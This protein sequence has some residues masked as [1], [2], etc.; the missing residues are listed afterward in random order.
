[1]EA[2]T[3][4]VAKG[5]PDTVIAACRKVVSL[6][7]LRVANLR[8]LVGS[9]PQAVELYRKSLL[10]EDATQTRTAL[11]TAALFAGQFDEVIAQTAK[12]LESN[13]ND[14]RLWYLNGKGWMGKLDY[15]SAVDSL[16]QSLALRRDVNTQYAL[17][18]SYLKLKDKANGESVIRETLEQQGDRP[19]WHIIFGG[20]YRES[21]YSQD[22]IREFRRAIAMNNTTPRA[23]LYLALA[24]LEANGWAPLEDSVREL[25]EAVSQ[26]PKDFHAN[27]YLG[28]QESQTDRIADSNKHLKAAAEIDSTLPEIWL[29]LGLN[30]FKE[31]KVEDAKAFL[32]KAIQLTGTNEALGGYEIRRGYTVLSRIEFAAGN[33]EIAKKYSEKAKELKTI[34]MVDEAKGLTN[35]AG[36]MGAPG[37]VPH[38][39]FPEQTLPKEYARID[40]T[41]RLE[42]AALAKTTLPLAEQKR[43]E[44]AEHDLRMVLSNAFNDWGT[45]DAR[46]GLYALA[47]QHFQEAEQWDSSTPGVA[48]NV[49]LAALKTGDVTEAIRGFR[50]AIEFD[51]KDRLSHARLAMLL[52]NQND[53]KGAAAQFDILGDAAYVDSAVAYSYAYSLAQLNQPKKAIEVLNRLSTMQMP[54]ELLLS[55]GDLYSV[56]QD[57]ED[58]LL[59]YRKALELEPGIPKA[60]YKMGAALIRLSR[61]AEA[62]PELQ[63]ELNATPD[64][65]DVQFNL[66]YALLSTSQKEKARV[67][68][69]KITTQHPEY[70]AAQYELGKSLLEDGKVE[71]AIAHLEM[72]AKLDSESDYVH[73]Q[74]QSAYR[75]AGRKEEADREAQIY[76][77]IKARKREQATIPMPE[78]KP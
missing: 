68:L 78:R 45:A 58:A 26:S 35:I 44:S 27:L 38:S 28:L 37:I 31:N 10:V 9:Y 7:F 53:Y 60:H 71:E 65:P 66:A 4:A 2:E 16:K 36:G 8:M 11:A 64:D 29:Y 72:A 55:V 40:P 69:Q 52:F 17:A 23:H 74:L 61:P 67:I 73:Y 21:G 24:M 59:R 3:A 15:R 63:A 62:V 5:S 56:L 18:L 12:L 19:I 75:R 14:N 50:A 54:A 47:L 6:A 13:P 57:Y 46:N 32:L 33:A 51:P 30:A 43:I 22:A 76:K 48:R 49:G 42:S 77:D 39:S 34:A 20:A 25:R 70:S 1:V 41:A